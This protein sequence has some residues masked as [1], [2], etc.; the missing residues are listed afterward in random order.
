MMTCLRD[1]D[2]IELIGSRVNLTRL[3]ATKYYYTV[4]KT[5]ESIS[6]TY[7]IDINFMDKCSSKYVCM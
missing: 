5:T 7:Y 4:F 1:L 2:Q 3:T 6:I